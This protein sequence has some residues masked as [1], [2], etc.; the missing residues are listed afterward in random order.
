[1]FI[2]IVC[3]HTANTHFSS[4]NML[5]AMSHLTMANLL[6]YLKQYLNQNKMK[7]IYNLTLE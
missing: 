5:H 2:I 1:M 3:K 6:I 7:K 4:N